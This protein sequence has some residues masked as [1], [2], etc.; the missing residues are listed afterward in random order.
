MVRSLIAAI[1]SRREV[2][3]YVKE[4][5]TSAKIDPH[6][7]VNV[8]SGLAAA[9]HAAMMQRHSVAVF[10]TGFQLDTG[11]SSMALAAKEADLLWKSMC[12]YLDL[13]P[14]TLRYL[15]K[16]VV[17]ILERKSKADWGEARLRATIMNLLIG[18]IIIPAL[19]EAIEYDIVDDCVMSDTYFAIA[20]HVQ[21]IL[22]ALLMGAPLAKQDPLAMLANPLIERSQYSRQFIYRG[23]VKEY[24]TKLLNFELPNY[25]ADYKNAY[26]IVTAEGVCLTMSNIHFLFE[27]IIH[28]YAYYSQKYPAVASLVKRHR[29][30]IIV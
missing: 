1:T 15:C 27:L 28:N 18:K 8:L 29:F 20:S 13:M 22:K 26:E 30:M 11:V 21:K 16:M 12:K 19:F 17:Q 4:L 10:S 24:I 9:P 5:F 3:E 2:T 25:E 7:P 6:T 23:E 14:A